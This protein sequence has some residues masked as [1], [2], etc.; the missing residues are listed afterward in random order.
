MTYLDSIEV[1]LAGSGD[2][3][4]DQNDIIL[5]AE[6]MEGGGYDAIIGPGSY[7]TRSSW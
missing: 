6:G 1:V 5:Q 4:L 7:L 2:A 3:I